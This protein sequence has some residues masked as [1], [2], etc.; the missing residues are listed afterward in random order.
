MNAVKGKGLRGT[1]DLVARVLMFRVLV[2]GVNG[3]VM[4]AFHGWVENC[5][6]ATGQ[7]NAERPKLN[8]G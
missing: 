8:Y 4:R 6:Q 1:D 5:A 3:K 2:L 7:Q